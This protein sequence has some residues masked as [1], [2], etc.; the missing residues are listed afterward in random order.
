MSPSDDATGRGDID[1]VAVHLERAVNALLSSASADVVSEATLQR[2]T[3]SA[4]RL[5]AHHCATVGRVD[6]L[7]K[8][9]S[10]TEA[11]ELACGLLR[12][13]DL[14][15]FDLALWYSRS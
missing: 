2:L 1:D 13:R 12:S 3:T 7:H 6:P 9:A 8:E 5:Y 15:P 14:N 10:P 11:V 4:T